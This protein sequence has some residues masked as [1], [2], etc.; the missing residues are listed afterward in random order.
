MSQ[1]NISSSSSIKVATIPLYSRN[2]VYYGKISGEEVIEGRT[3]YW[4]YC[5][6]TADTNYYGYVYSDF[7]DE[8][9][10]TMPINTEEVTYIQN[11]TFE[12]SPAEKT[13]SIP[14]KSSKT[15]II[16]AILTIPAIAFFFMIIK[17]KNII[18]KQKLKD[19]EIVDY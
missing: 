8:M 7:C 3:N 11:P 6:F 18:T 13:S 17:G 2:I 19:K 16:V 4:Y 14:M 12:S 9:P 15:G 5:K 10:A 1:P